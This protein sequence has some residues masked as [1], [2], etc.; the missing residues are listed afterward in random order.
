MAK[1]RPRVLIIEDDFSIRTQLARVLEEEGYDV[2]SAADG[3]EGLDYLLTHAYP[4]VIVLDIYMPHM[5]G[6]EFLQ[7][8][9][10]SPQL[11]SIPVIAVS[12]A[13]NLKRLAPHLP[14]AAQVSKPI[15]LD[16]FI[17]IVKGQV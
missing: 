10:R 1:G 9:Q 6:V 3:A 15:D 17:D 13:A 2:A 14:V 4:K 12:A 7:E 8:M 11:A 16:A 5:D